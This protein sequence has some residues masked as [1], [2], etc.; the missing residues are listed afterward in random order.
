M[1]IDDIFTR[2]LHKLDLKQLITLADSQNILLTEV[3]QRDL[4]YLVQE[5]AARLD[6]YREAESALKRITKEEH[7]SE[8]NG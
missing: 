7:G 5:L 4:V 2:G 3:S 6:V 8:F 1:N